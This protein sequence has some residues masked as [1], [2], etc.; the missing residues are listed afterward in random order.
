MNLKKVATQ[1]LDEVSGKF[2]VEHKDN[3]DETITYSVHIELDPKVQKE[4]AKVMPNGMKRDDQH[5]DLTIAGGEEE[6][7]Q[8]QP[9]EDELPGLFSTLLDSLDV[10]KISNVLKQPQSQTV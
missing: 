9:V 6:E 5:D 4:M 3:G 7:L 1:A 2:P 10:N 8:P